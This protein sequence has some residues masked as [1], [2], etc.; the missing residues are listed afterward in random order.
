MC[1]DASVRRLCGPCD[2]AI[3]WDQNNGELYS[4]AYEMNSWGDK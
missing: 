2:S 1:G 3:G 4:D